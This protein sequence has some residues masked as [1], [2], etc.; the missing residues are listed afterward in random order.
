MVALANKYHHVYCVLLSIINQIR[1]DA[2]K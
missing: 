1:E 2:D